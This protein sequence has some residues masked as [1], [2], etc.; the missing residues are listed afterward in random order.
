[1]S[2]I[3]LLT[4][5]QRLLRVLRFWGVILLLG[6]GY[7]AFAARFGGL[8]CVFR[9]ITGWKCPGCGVTHMCLEL[10]HGDVSGAF[11]ENGAV[12]LLSPVIIGLLI[13]QSIRYVR[14]GSLR[15]L[16]WEEKLAGVIAV[17]LVLFG[18]GR[19]LVF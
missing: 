16:P 4:S 18:I 19:N 10:L 5:N 8:P 1:M 9:L 3:R 13:H 12:L 11:R 7:A 2:S 6:F 17:I 14:A 15:L